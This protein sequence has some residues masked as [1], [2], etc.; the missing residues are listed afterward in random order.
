MHSLSHFAGSGRKLQGAL[1]LWKIL[2]SWGYVD[3]H[4]T[5]TAATAVIK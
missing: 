5:F 3:H 4:H 2:C 1:C